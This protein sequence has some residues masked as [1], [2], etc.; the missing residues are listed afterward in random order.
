MNGKIHC[1]QCDN[2]FCF[3]KEHCSTIWIDKIDDAKV[4]IKHKPK[5]NIFREGGY[6]HGI[7]FIQRGQV[8]IIATGDKKREQ[9]VR[10]ASDGQVLGHRGNG[11]D[12]YPVSAVALSGTVVCFVDNELLHGAL[13][14]NPVLT[15]EL[16]TYYS[17]ELRKV[18]V[19]MKYLVQMTVTEKI[20]E[21][22]LY[23]DEIFGTQG[24]NL[25]DI[26][27]S[28]Q[29][30]AD[31]SGVKQEQVSRELRFLEESKLITRQGRSIKAVNIS[32]LNNL[33]RKYNVS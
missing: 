2:K 28:R 29:E 23:M 14:D 3:I 8:K 12:R 27:L 31:I 1:S 10:L 24:N 5:D 6:V 22:F 30:I 20:A 18:E 4:Q 15:L 16:M 19:R 26:P 32:G 21:A 25:F 17:A 13:M 7:Y 9:I 33:I 11:Q